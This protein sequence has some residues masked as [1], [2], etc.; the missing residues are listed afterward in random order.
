MLLLLVSS[1]A[2]A[3]DE[4]PPPDPATMQHE[5][6]RLSIELHRLVAR[7]AWSGVERTFEKMR[8][9]GVTM[10]FEDLVAGA[11][12]ARAFGDVRAVKERL[13]EAS[14]LESS[15]EVLG[16]MWEIESAY[17]LV[18]LACDLGKKSH[19]TLQAAARPFDPNQQRAVDF[20]VAQIQEGC[21]FD[22][23]LPGGQYTF[24][25]HRFEVVPRVRS[26]R[27]DLRG[28]DKRRVRKESG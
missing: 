4:G 6:R 3:R 10:Q 7:N 16:W 27:I 19:E 28:A 18:F 12:A 2:V 9:T 1:S 25:D 22:G 26:V 24:G 11:S 13:Y 23:M 20:A 14:K 15:Q 8:Q 17:G 21:V 5:Y